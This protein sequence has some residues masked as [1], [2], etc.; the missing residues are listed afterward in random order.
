MGLSAEEK[1]LPTSRFKN[2]ES[3]DRFKN[4]ALWRPITVIRHKVPW[5]YNRDPNNPKVALPDEKAREFY[6]KAYLYLFNH[7]YEHVSQWLKSVGYPI[8]PDGLYNMLIERP[9]WDEIQ[10]PLEERMKL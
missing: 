9:V 7:S 6:L 4:L 3:I 1:S 8:G 5:G 10:L 2:I